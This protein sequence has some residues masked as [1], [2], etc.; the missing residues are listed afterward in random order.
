MSGF[1]NELGKKLAERWLS[2]LVLPGALYLAVATTAYTLGWAHA[3]DLHRL[4]TILTTW[5][6]TPPATTVGGQVVLV[7]GVLAA[8]AAVGLAAQ[9]LGSVTER[10]ALAAGWQA[11]WRPLRGLAEKRVTSRRN[12]WNSAHSDYHRLYDQARQAHQAGT[13]P[14]PNQREQ[15][16]AAY[17]ALTRIALEE[18]ERPTWTG[19]RIH[20]VTLRLR[21]DLNLDLPT[22]WPSL[23]LHLPDTTRTEITTARQALTTATTLTGWALLYAPLTWWWWPAALIAAGTALT[24]WRRTRTTTDIYARLLEAT[25]RLHTRTLSEHLGIDTTDATLPALGNTLTHHLHT[26]L[27]PPPVQAP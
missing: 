13:Q 4:I 2:L 25:A 19:D 3:G 14:N 20:A 27:P 11:W 22:V 12:D 7:A 5:A 9:A 21:R 23:W 10:L 26:Q 18:P 1:L 16:H 24:A 6:K 15:R 17:R 8:S